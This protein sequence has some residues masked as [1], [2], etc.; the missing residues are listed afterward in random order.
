MVTFP[1]ADKA[2]WFDLPTARQKMHVGQ[3]PFLDQL[4]AI[5][6]ERR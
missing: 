4:E 5:L 3:L 2:A 6:R 1:E